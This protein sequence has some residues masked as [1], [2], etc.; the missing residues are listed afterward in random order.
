[1]LLDYDAFSE[2]LR[3]IDKRDDVIVTIW[4]GMCKCIDCV[5]TS[6]DSCVLV[7]LP[8]GHSAREC[9]EIA[10]KIKQ[11]SDDHNGIVAQTLA[12]ASATRMVAF[13]IALSTE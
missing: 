10:C 8:D 12:G 1:M 3:G 9:S 11:F 4:Q 13:G 6:R 2:A 5:V 7:Q